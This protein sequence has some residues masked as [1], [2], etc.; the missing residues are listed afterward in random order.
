MKSLALLFVLFTST[1]QASSFEQGLMQLMSANLDPLVSRQ[2]PEWI[3]QGKVVLSRGNV[4]VFYATAEKTA[5]KEQVHLWYDTNMILP[6]LDASERTALAQ[7]ELYHETSKIAN[8][9]SGKYPL[10]AIADK[11]SG[12]AKERAERLWYS[13]FEIIRGEWGLVKKMGMARI[14]PIVQ[15]EMFKGDTPQNFLE[16]YYQYRLYND[17]L[18]D[19]GL[20]KELTAIYE[21]EKSK[22]PKP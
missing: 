9:F 17:R 21:R 5:K 1:P 2:L 4:G 18:S 22:I 8:H 15:K 16:G 11:L 19:A 7:L 13:E 10:L 12:T 3:S 14:M 20:A 6:L